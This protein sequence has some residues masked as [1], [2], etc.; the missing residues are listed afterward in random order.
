MATGQARQQLQVLKNI[1]ETIN[2]TK[3]FN[4]NSHFK[5]RTRST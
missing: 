1:Y 5:K 4:K 2:L 3:I